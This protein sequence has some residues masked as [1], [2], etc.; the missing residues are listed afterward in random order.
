MSTLSFLS[1]RDLVNFS[2]VEPPK[3]IANAIN[4]ARYFM[5]TN[6][7]PSAAEETILRSFEK[8]PYA[9]SD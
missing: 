9:F 4:F 8:R 3:A 1:R 7:N 2:R 5:S 6:L